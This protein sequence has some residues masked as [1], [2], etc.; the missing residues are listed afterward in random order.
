M[1]SD[2]ISVLLVDDQALIRQ[3]VADLVDQEP[4]IDVVGQAGNG[5]E[6]VETARRL[7]P[8]VVLMDIR[9]PIMNGVEATAA[10]RALPELDDTRVVVLTT[11]E[12]DDN[13]LTALRAGASGFVGKGTSPEALADAI[14]TVH[15]GDALL[16]PQ[17]TRALIDRWLSPAKPPA[18]PRPPV[19]DELTE[20]ESDILLRIARGRTNADIAAD[21]YL[22]PHTV[23]T[24]AHRIMAKIGAHD[25][26]QMVVFAYEHGVVA[27]GSRDAH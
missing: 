20:R 26:A 5:R 11:F 6:A 15:A 23:K 3:A 24:H 14:R 19:L 21:L 17:A 12:N 22:S 25:R 1:T 9:M 27:P 7:R 8:D 16:S 10:I 18:V 13:A 2:P 4:D